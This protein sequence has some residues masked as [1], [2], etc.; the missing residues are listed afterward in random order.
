MAD[1]ALYRLDD[2]S[3]KKVDGSM[4]ISWLRKE[5]AKGNLSCSGLD[6]TCGVKVEPFQTTNAIFFRAKRG[7]K[8]KLGCECD[9]TDAG[10]I[11]YNLDHVGRDI[12]PEDLFEKFSKSKPEEENESKKMNKGTKIIC[13]NYSD[14]D[15]DFEDD[16]AIKRET[17]DP[18]NLR[19][20]CA[21]L[22][23]KEPD[24]MY[25]GI[26]VGDMFI[27]HRNIAEIRRSGISE[28]KPIIMLLSQI[29]LKRIDSLGLKVPNQAIVLGDAY[30]YEDHDEQLICIIP[31]TMA[32]RKKIFGISDK[33]KD[34]GKKKVYTKGGKKV[35][36]I[37]GKWRK[38]TSNEGAYICDVIDIGQVFC[39]DKKFYE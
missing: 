34:E 20:L 23:K 19:E 10:K 33:K 7:Q 27:D 8:H 22:S 29:S 16:R 9:D 24:D 2:G 6:E 14:E 32:A 31:C 12:T 28:G 17:R 3:F 13:I 26:C 25:A 36:A 15:K 11:I 4:G 39:S 37:Y 35:I 18:R 5:A 1:I 30:S 21:L 38:D